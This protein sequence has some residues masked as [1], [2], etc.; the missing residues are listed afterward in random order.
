MKNRI[1]ENCTLFLNFKFKFGPEF[2]LESAI[3]FAKKKTK[4]KTEK[5]KQST[6]RVALSLSAQTLKNL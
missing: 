2:L 5:E 1:A 4:T 3:G 6:Q